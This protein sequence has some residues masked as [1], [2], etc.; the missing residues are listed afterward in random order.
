M[1]PACYFNGFLF[2]IFGASGAAITSNPWVIGIAVILTLIGFF[3]MWKAWL[4]R[5]PGKVMKN[6]KTTI[7]FTLVFIAGFVTASFITHE[8]FKNS[9]EQIKMNLYI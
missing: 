2:L 4:K 7:L 5:S 8:Y 3:W 1:C 9:Y 6:I